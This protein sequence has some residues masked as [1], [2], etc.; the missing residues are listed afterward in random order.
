MSTHSSPTTLASQAL[1]AG[2]T[3]TSATIDN[4]AGYGAV[5]TA[6]VTNG[7]TGPTAPCMVYLEISTDGSNFFIREN[8]AADVYASGVFTFCFDIP[9]PVLYVRVRFNGNTGQSVTVA[10]QTHLMTGG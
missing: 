3:A 4:T 7:A 2:G 6:Q 8:G 10:A 9:P 5:I 1:A